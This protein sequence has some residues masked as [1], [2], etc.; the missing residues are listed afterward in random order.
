MQWKKEFDIANSF[1]EFFELVKAVVRESIGRERTGLMLGFTELGVQAHGFIGGY[2]PV[3]SNFIVM[4][5]TAARMIAANKPELYKAYCF[6]ILLHE[7]LH[8]M[9]FLDELNTRTVAHLITKEAFGESH[10]TTVVST[11]FNEMLK[12]V[13]MDFQP[14]PAR[15]DSGIQI[16]SDFDTGNVSYIG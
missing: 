14:V 2:H 8:T 1:G 7:Y 15:H 11:R 5:K 3:G 4:N 12:D 16:V 6:H 13:S 9:G 10:P